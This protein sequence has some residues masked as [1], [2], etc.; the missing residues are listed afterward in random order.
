[1]QSEN[2]I[3]VF[4]M[5]QERYGSLLEFSNKTFTKHSFLVFEIKC[6][7]ESVT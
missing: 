4:C 3:V 1:M 2:F 5:F 6:S 7:S